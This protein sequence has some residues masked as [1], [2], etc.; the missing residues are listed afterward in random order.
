M[1]TVITV[2]YNDAD[3]LKRTIESVL[4]QSSYDFEF[5]IKDGGS[6]DNTRSIVEGYNNRLERL[7]SFKYV[8]S[9]DKGIYDAMNV[10]TG[11][12][13][14]E[15]IN[16]LNAGDQ[17]YDANVIK[18]LSEFL[19]KTEADVIYGD[20]K[21]CY[22]NKSK[23]V[24]VTE[25]KEFLKRGMYF[26]HQASFVRRS[27]ALS[28]PFNL[29]FRI[30]S[31]YNFFVECYQKGKKFEYLNRIIAV[32]QI[33]GLSYQKPFDLL[34]DAYTVRFEHGFIGAEEYKKLVGEAKGN[35]YV[36]SLIPA[37]IKKIL[38]EKRDEKRYADWDTECQ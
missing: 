1:I 17:Y 26:N 18:D 27:L 20:V 32:F 28:N 9:K 6:T 38:Q 5:I 36:R 19:Y 29:K 11:M 31:D 16:Y 35:K 21:K 22:K 37:I 15:W 3:N 30:C 4:S 34:I 12:A 25:D 7:R 10:A 24:Y 2:C 23:I 33:G 8:C 13:S 14:G